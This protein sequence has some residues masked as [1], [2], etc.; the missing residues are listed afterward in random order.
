MLFAI[1]LG[2]YPSII[3]DVLHYSTYNLLYTIDSVS[4]N[5]VIYASSPSPDN[6]FNLD[7]GDNPSASDKPSTGNTSST[8]NTGVNLNTNIVEPS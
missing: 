7:T 3:L 2:I 5:I 4:E 1:S 6:N 8:G